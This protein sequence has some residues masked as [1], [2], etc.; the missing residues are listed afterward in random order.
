MAKNA[1][2]SAL[3]ALV[4][5]CVSCGG[6]EGNRQA[7]ELLRAIP[8]DALAL[9]SFDRVD[10]GI[11]FALDSS[12]VLRTLDFGRFSGSRMVMSMDN[13]GSVEQLLAIDAGHASP[14]TSEAAKKLM[15]K[16]GGCGIHC[17]YICG[18]D[19]TLSRNVLLL[20]TSETV[21][22]VALRHIGASTSILDA[23]Y[24]DQVLECPGATCNTMILRNSGAHKLLTTKVL[25]SYFPHPKLVKFVHGFSEW[26]V[27]DASDCSHGQFC[28]EPVRDESSKYFSK[29]LDSVDPASSRLPDMMPSN[30]AFA[31]DMPIG[32][33]ETFREA[34]E[35]WKDA[36]SSLESYRKNIKNLKKTY[37]KDP[38]R[39]E[40]ELGIKE[41]S[42][43]CLED[44]SSL[45]LV[46]T[47]HSSKGQE[48]CPNP[49]P[50]YVEALFGSAFASPADSCQLYVRDWVVTGSETAVRTFS[51]TGPGSVGEWPGKC[52]FTIWTPAFSIEGRKEGITLSVK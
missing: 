14:D 21:V 47:S 36:G 41:V 1:S 49:Y 50:G 52:T 39:W 45:T 48:I 16:A 17:A 18:S 27:V 37:G 15:S 32:D 31:I 19:T 40:K 2:I 30:A 3:V 29:L 8:S 20:S 4:L 13:V 22:N 7:S 6:G 23:P 10:D 42:R 44:G 26:I 33:R 24:F 51:E 43:V 25:D 11:G 38:L 35:S 34:Y 9:V 46:R 12:H 5:L 28:I